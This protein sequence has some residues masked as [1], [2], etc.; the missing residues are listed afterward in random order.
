M[1]AF[2]SRILV[3]AIGLPIVLWLAWEGGWWLLLLA[4]AAG[5]MALHEF[6]ALERRMRPVLIAGYAGVVLTLVGASRGGLGWM[7]AGFLATLPIAYVLKGF[8]DTRAPLVVSLA[9]TVL[10]V[11]WVGFG[12]AHLILLRAIPEHGRLAIFTVLIAVFAGDTAA[13]FGGRLFG[14]RKLAPAISPGK[15]WEGFVFGTVATV[16]ATW[17]CL[18][19]SGFLDNGRALLLGAVIAIVGPI[20]DLFESSLKREAG[21]KDSGRLLAGHGG[22]L[23]RIDAHL[24]A[25][26]AAFYLIAAFGAT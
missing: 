22:V 7:A 11:A 18:Y 25:S 15:T 19:K 3:G 2:W 20:G 16:F 14:R 13:Y 10:G 4:A 5:L 6:Y 9:T 24:F 17:I 1:T 12:L 8:A 26:V 23:D 21:V